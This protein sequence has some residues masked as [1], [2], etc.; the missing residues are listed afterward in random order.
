MQSAG[1]PASFVLSRRFLILLLLLAN[2]VINFADRVNLSIA[3]QE[4]AKYFHWDSAQMGWILSA[5]LWTYTVLLIPSGWI[6]DRYGTRLVSAVSIAVWSAAAMV[7]GAVTGLA[8]ML[9]ARSVLGVGEAAAMPACNKVIRQWIPLQERGVATAIFHSGVFFSVVIGSPAI[10]WLVIHTGWRASFYIMGALGFVWLAAWLLW[11]DTPEM[12]KWL[13]S[14]ERSYILE[15]RDRTEA[16][17]SEFWKSVRILARQKTVW[18]IALTEG[19][20]NYM[21]YMFLTWLPSYLIKDRGMD[22]MKAGIYSSIPYLVGIVLEVGFGKMSDSL[23]TTAQVKQGGR[24][25]HVIVFMLLCTVILTINFVNAQWAI[26]TIIALAL[27]FNATTVT[28]MYSLTNDLVEDPRLVGG[29]FGFMLLGGNLFGLAAP[30]VTGYLVR[31]AGNFSSAF[32]IAG[33]LPLVGAATAWLM[34][35][36]PIRSQQE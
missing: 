22:L 11:F 24:R 1:G 14:G 18:G 7:T 13:S 34:I 8:G 31:S 6:V 20:V 10:A 35:R 28:F 16:R 2:V 30:I 4:V 33:L 12:A 21:N 26:I 25:A 19:C 5:Y 27:S 17:S 23:L 32:V 15:N 36:E 3:A 9:A 29:A